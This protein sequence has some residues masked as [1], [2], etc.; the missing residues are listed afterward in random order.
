[1]VNYEIAYPGRIFG[2]HFLIVS[3]LVAISTFTLLLVSVQAIPGSVARFADISYSSYLLHLPLGSVIFAVFLPY[4]PFDASAGLAFAV[5]LV[6]SQ[7]NYAIVERPSR[8]FATTLRLSRSF[9]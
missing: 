7:L 1:V 6:A 4:I 3:Y 8:R 9:K 5:I 2:T